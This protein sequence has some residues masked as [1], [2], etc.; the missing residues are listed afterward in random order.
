MFCQR[1]ARLLGIRKILYCLFYQKLRIHKYSETQGI[2]LT[3]LILETILFPSLEF[4]T[5]YIK[6]KNYVKKVVEC[7]FKVCNIMLKF[8]KS[9]VI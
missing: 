3:I 1:K 7:S 2:F 8:P 6:Y 5:L 4:L 9:D